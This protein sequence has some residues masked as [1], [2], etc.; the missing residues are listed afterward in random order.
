MK[1]ITDE[2]MNQMLQNTKTYTQV[3]LKAGPNY[4]QPDNYPIVWEH[5]RRNFALREEG[6][7]NIV[8]PVLDGDDL[9]GIVIFNANQ[10]QTRKIM[11]DDP[12]V[13]A[14]IL[15][16]EVYTIRSFPGDTL[17]E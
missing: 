12:S 2:F 15:V 17:A 16:F 5:G 11:E 6:L 9:K 4:N 13:Q 3:F 8:A 1:T 7:I 14:G 10:D